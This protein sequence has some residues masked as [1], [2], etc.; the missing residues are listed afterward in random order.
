MI[1]GVVDPMAGLV[2][3]VHS[4][5]S[6]FRVGSPC[7][8]D[9]SVMSEPLPDE[10][11]ESW[12]LGPDIN[13]KSNEPMLDS[14]PAWLAVEAKSQD[15]FVLRLRRD[16]YRPMPLGE[17]CSPSSINVISAVSC[18]FLGIAVNLMAIT[19]VTTAIF[20]I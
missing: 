14:R 9:D 4:M 18:L 13:L 16:L 3:V 20:R 19:D 7:I 8:S 1:S 5:I 2:A 10:Q 15:S 12:D 6:M 11:S 17:M